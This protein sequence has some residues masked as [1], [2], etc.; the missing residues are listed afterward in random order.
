MIFFHYG[1][2]L[3]RDRSHACL[4]TP[5]TDEQLFNSPFP[6]LPPAVSC[7]LIR[8]SVYHQTCHCH[9]HALRTH[10]HT[11][12]TLPCAAGAANQV[13]SGCP[14]MLQT[15]G[16]II[17]LTVSYLCHRVLSLL[18]SYPYLSL[19]PKFSKELR[20]FSDMLVFL[21]Q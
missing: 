18:C 21:I 3:G 13:H 12:D 9:Q 7:Y 20:D 15:K 10:H 11:Q 17:I 16:T 1:Y 5:S 6:S 14:G 19:E 4:T 8:R 2:L